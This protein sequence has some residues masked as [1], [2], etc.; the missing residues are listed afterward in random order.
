VVGSIANITPDGFP[1]A[2]FHSYPSTLRIDGITGDYGPGFLSHALNTGT[3]VAHHPEFGWVAFGGNL[4][5]EGEVVRVRPLDSARSRVFLAPLGLW[6]TL[7]AG[8]FEEVEISPRGVSL[9]LS[10]ATSH[11]PTALLRIEQP[12]PVPGVGAFSPETTLQE[13]RGA[14]VIPLGTEA[15]SVVLRDGGSQEEMR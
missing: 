12:A 8:T 13:E 2:A 11:T 15:T 3:Y 5:E 10:P 6:L 9:R 4:T 1:P 14:F 7:D